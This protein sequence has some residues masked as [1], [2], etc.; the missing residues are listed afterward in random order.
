MS[1]PLPIPTGITCEYFYIPYRVQDKIFKASV[2]I[3]SQTTM[4]EVKS[5]IAEYARDF[6]KK[7]ITPYEFV[8]AR[9]DNSDF[10]LY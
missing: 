5:H 7:P 9:I 6:Y 10:T 3:G 2:K 1:I 8:V 4:M